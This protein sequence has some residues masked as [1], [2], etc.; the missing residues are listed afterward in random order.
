MAEPTQSQNEHQNQNQD[1]DRTQNQIEDH[2]SPSARPPRKRRRPAKACDPCRR[3]KVRCDQELPCNQCVRAKAP[4]QCFYIPNVAVN[5]PSIAAVSL[6]GAEQTLGAPT[7]FDLQAQTRPKDPT[8]VAQ[9]S[10]PQ[11]QREIIHD[12][13]RRLRHLE[14]QLSSPSQSVGQ[15]ASN[16]S[17]SQ[18]QRHLQGR[19]LGAEQQISDPTRGNTLGNGCAIPATLPRLRITA[20]KTKLFGPSHWLHTAEK[21][22]CTDSPNLISV[23]ADQR[24]IDSS[25]S[26]VNSMPKK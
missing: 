19:I 15:A 25:K 26:L 16:P 1:E 9:Y 14:E 7:H 20:E 11:Q 23:V 21:V 17:V 6:S 12:L 8:Q 2:R 22:R 24:A 10:E 4:L 3:R 18:S 5:S 13:Q